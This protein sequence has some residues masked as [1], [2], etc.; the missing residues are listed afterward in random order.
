MTD[1]IVSVIESAGI[2]E[3]LKPDFKNAFINEGGY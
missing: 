1:I 2:G 3:I